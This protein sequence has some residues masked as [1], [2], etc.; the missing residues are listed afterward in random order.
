MVPAGCQDPG[1]GDR[2]RIDAEAVRQAQPGEA[3]PPPTVAL[4]PAELAAT[5]PL[6]DHTVPHPTVEPAPVGTAAA[7][8]PA[9]RVTRR[10]YC[11]GTP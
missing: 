5:L 6:A 11:C 1:W 10:G 4:E 8:A 7:V 3:L 9:G 2:P